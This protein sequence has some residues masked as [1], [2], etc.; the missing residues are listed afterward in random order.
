[1]TLTGEVT[2][3]NG[4][5]L[6]VKWYRLSSG[7]YIKDASLSETKPALVTVKKYKSSKTRY[8]SSTSVK[9]WKYPSTKG[10]S[11]T[12]CKL[13]KGTKIKVTAKA[14]KYRGKKLSA[15]WYK[16]RFT[17]NGKTYTGYVKSKFLTAKKPSS[18]S[19]SGS[20]K[21][22]S[23][24]DGLY[25]GSDKWTD[26]GLEGDTWGTPDDSEYTGPYIDENSY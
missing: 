16:I 25:S 18:S 26:I 19:S 9:I 8:I 12:L 24:S 23:S 4:K 15:T 2:S 10:S 13:T 17:K 5:E 20:S 14:T 3:Y 11:T 1:V 22:S 7:L 6:T 21:S